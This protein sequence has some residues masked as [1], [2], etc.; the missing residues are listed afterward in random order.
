MK[1]I[2]KKITIFFALAIFLIGGFFP[3][4][5]AASA[6]GLNLGLAPI[7]ASGLATTDIR[8]IIANIIRVALGL[9]GIGAVGLIMYA[10][11][12]W[13]TAGGNEEQIATAKKIL[14]NATIGLIIILSAY[15]IVSF[16]ITQLQGATT[17]QDQKCQDQRANGGPTWGGD[18]PTQDCSQ[19]ADGC[20]PPGSL[21]VKNLPTQGKMC[22][23]N[24]RPMVGF[25]KSVDLS[26]LN[27]NLVVVLDTTT[28][29]GACAPENYFPGTWSN[30]NGDDNTVVFTPSSSCPAADGGKDCFAASTSYKIRFCNSAAILDLDHLHSLSCEFGRGCPDSNFITGDGVDRTP[31]S[32]I[33]IEDL[34]NNNV[35]AQDTRTTVNLSYVDDV[36]VQSILLKEGNN[37]IGS[38][39]F[40]GCNMSNTGQVV[41]DTSGYSTGTYHLKATG[42]DF[43]G[44]SNSSSIKDVQVVLPHCVDQTKNSDETGIDCGGGCPQCDG[45]SCTV[46]TDCQSGYCEVTN[47]RGICLEKMYIKSISPNP[48]AHGDFLSILGKYFGETAGH[49]YFKSSSSQDIEAPVANCGVGFDNWISNQIIVQVPDGAVSGTVRVVTAPVTGPDGVVRQWEDMTGVSGTQKIPDFILT[50][51]THPGICGILPQPATGQPGSDVS[52]VGKNF[53]ANKNTNDYFKFYETKLNVTN[54]ADTTVSGTVPLTLGNGDVG[55]SIEKNGIQ[56]NSVLFNIF[57][58]VLNGPVITSM[59]ATSGVFGDYLTIY[60]NNFGGIQNQVIFTKLDASGNQTINYLVGGTNFPSVCNNGV[61]W[62]DNQIVVKMPNFESGK[63]YSVQVVRSDPDSATSPFDDTKTVTDMPGNVVKPGICK[64]SPTSG[65]VPG[66]ITIFGENFEVGSNVYFSQTTSTKD[67]LN[68]YSSDT[69][70]SNNFIIATDGGETAAVSSTKS[71]VSGPVFVVKRGMRSNGLMFKVFDCRSTDNSN[72]CAGKC[73]VDGADA[74]SCI[75][76]GGLCSGDHKSSGYMWVFSANRLAEQP[77]VVERCGSETERAVSPEFPSPSPSTFWGG[78]SEQVCHTALPNVEFS[79]MMSSTLLNAT[80]VQVFSCGNGANFD[81]GNCNT[82]FPVTIDIQN[83]G[84]SRNYIQLIPQTA[85]PNRW[86]PNTWYQVRLI[87]GDSGIKTDDVRPQPLLASRPC[88]NGAA[89]YCFDFKTSNEDV[90][91]GD[92]KLRTVLVSPSSFWTSIIDAAIPVQVIGINSNPYDL[93]YQ[94]NGLSTQ[95]CTLMNV[96]DLNWEWNTDSTTLARTISSVH[97]ANNQSNVL[98][99]RNTVGVGIDGDA[100]KIEASVHPTQGVCAYDNSVSCSSNSDCTYYKFGY[101]PIFRKPGVCSAV[102]G[103]NNNVYLVGYTGGSTYGVPVLDCNNSSDCN[104]PGF[105]DFVKSKGSGWSPACNLSSIDIVPNNSTCD[106]SQLKTGT[107]S[108]KIDLSNPEVIDYAPNC[109]EAC[110]NA[111]VWARFNTSMSSHNVTN[112]SAAIKISKCNDENCLSLTLVTSTNVGFDPDNLTLNIFGKGQFDSLDVNSL[113]LVQL[114][115]TDTPGIDQGTQL[116][117][118]SSTYMVKPYNKTFSWRFR[119]KKTACAPTSVDVLPKVF[120]AARLDD[121]KVFQAD[122]FSAPDACSASGQKLNPW[123]QDWNWSTSDVGVAKIFTVNTIGHNPYCNGNCLKNGSTVPFTSVTSTIYP[124]C[125]NGI[126]E[127]GEDCDSPV[128]STASNGCQLNCL[129]YPKYK[130]AGSQPVTDSKDLN[131]SVC[132]NGLLGLDEDCDLGISPL[133]SSPTSSFLCSANCLHQGTRLSSAWCANSASTS[134]SGFSDSD[135]KKFCASSYSQCGDGVLSPDEDPGCDGPG[136]TTLPVDCNNR[137]LKISGQCTPGSVGCGDDGLWQGSSLM[138]TK[139]GQDY[140]SVCGDGNAATGEDPD[141][142]VLQPSMLFSHPFTDPWVLA[143][144]EGNGAVS[145]GVP[146]VQESDITAETNTSTHKVGGFGKYQVPCGFASDQQCEDF[147]PGSGVG[148]DSCCYARPNLIGVYPGTTSTAN[149]QE[150]VCINTY[151]EA[152]FD[153]KIDVDTLSGNLLLAR[154]TPDSCPVGST[155]VSTL[156]AVSN[157]K[158]LAWYEII[159]QKLVAFFENIFAD[160]ATASGYVWCAGL[161]VGT[162]KVFFN[163][164]GSSK[165]TLSLSKPLAESTV[166]TVILKNDIKNINGVSIAKLSGKNPSWMFKTGDHICTI[167]TVTINPDQAFFS[168]PSSSAEFKAFGQTK[169]FIAGQ[170]QKIQ[171]VA[172]YSWEYLW[173]PAVN[174]YVEIATSGIDT[175]TITSKNRNGELDVFASAN[176]TADLYEN[177]PQVGIVATGKSHVIVFLCEN[178]WPPK[179]IFPYEDKVGNNDGFDI[180]SSI[181]DGS[182]IQPSEVYKGGYFNFRTYYCADNGDTG[183]ADD[184]PYLRPV[185]QVSGDVLGSSNTT[186]VTSTLTTLL[187][188]TGSCANDSNRTC[189]SSPDCSYVTVNNGVNNFKAYPNK[190]GVCGIWSKALKYYIY[191]DTSGFAVDCDTNADCSPY[192]SNPVVETWDTAVNGATPGNYDAL[193]CIKFSDPDMPAAVTS[194]CTFTPDTYNTSVSS[195]IIPIASGALKRFLF[196]NGKNNDAVGIQVFD[197][198]NHLSVYAWL[199]DKKFDTSNFKDMSSPLDGYQAV[200]DGDNVY[201]DALN[202]VGKDTASTTGNLSSNIYLFSLSKNSQPETRK[203]FEEL[204]Q[205]MSFNANLTNFGYCGTAVDKPNSVSQTSCNSDFDCRIAGTCTTAKVSQSVCAG[206]SSKHCIDPA[207]DCNPVIDNAFCQAAV[208]HVCSNNYAQSCTVATQSTDCPD[209]GAQ[210]MDGLSIYASGTEYLFKPAGVALGSVE[211]SIPSG[212]CG[213]TPHSYPSKISLAVDELYI[214]TSSVVSGDTPIVINESNIVACVTTQDCLDARMQG[215][216]TYN[217]DFDNWIKQKALYD[218]ANNFNY[219]FDAKCFPTTGPNYVAHYA[220]GTVSPTCIAKDSTTNFA[221]SDNPLKSCT[222]SSQCQLKNDTCTTINVDVSTCSNNSAK[223]CASD[224]E[225]LSLGI[226]ADQTDKLKRDYQRIKDLSTINQSLINYFSNNNSTY[227]SLKE[228]SFLTGQSVSTWPS[229]TTLGNVLGPILPIDPINQL[230]VAGTCSVSTN[231]FCTTDSDCG[232]QSVSSSQK[233]VIHAA[234]TGWSTAD[235]RFSFACATDSLAYRYIVS[236]SSNSYVVKSRFEDVG[237][238][239]QNLHPDF[240]DYFIPSSDQSKFN[241]TSWLNPNPN[242]GICNQDQEISTLSQGKCG[243]GQ[244]NLNLGEQCDPPGIKKYHTDVCSNPGYTYMPVEVCG[245]SCQW[246]P[247]NPSTSSCKILSKCGNGIVEPGEKC[248]DGAKNGSYNH[249]DLGCQ[250]FASHCGDGLVSSTYEVCDIASANINNNNN[251]NAPY[252]YDINTFTGWCVGGVN[253]GSGCF[254]DLTCNLYQFYNPFNGVYGSTVVGSSNGHCVTLAQNKNRYSLDKQK[255]CNFDCQKTGPYCGDGVVQPEFGEQCDKALDYSCS[256]DG[257]SG[258][259]V[260]G[261]SCR[262]ENNSAVVAYDFNDV[263]LYNDLSNVAVS[264]LANVAS[265]S[266]IDDNRELYATCTG[267]CP[268]TTTDRFGSLSKALNFN[269]NQY[270]TVTSSAKFSNIFNL[271]EITISAWVKV[272]STT[273]DGWHAILSKQNSDSG[274]PAS[275]TTLDRNYNFY[276]YTQNGEVVNLYFSSLALEAKPILGDGWALPQT[277][278]SSIFA[279]DTWNFVAVTVDASRNGKF[280][281]YDASTQK[282]IQ[283]GS[284]F[285]NGNPMLNATGSYP[286]FIGR[287]DNFFQGSIDDVQLYNRA[288]SPGEINDLSQNTNN[289]CQLNNVVSVPYV[290]PTACGN[291][292]VEDGED[293]DLGDSTHAPYQNGNVCKPG[294]FTGCWYC[295]SECKKINISGTLL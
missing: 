174:P 227:P 218:Q 170:P 90:G 74:G 156:V 25:N 162:P 229:W 114:S 57:G 65:D 118:G 39:N 38:A 71:T 107:S 140:P 212:L 93:V 104:T 66:T 73:C 23:M 286:V 207:T 139:N 48:A 120:T 45:G 242:N 16:V 50:T 267:N 99:F 32:S 240:Y 228:G 186:T 133:V 35:I 9:L 41:W 215:D 95:Y 44:L 281:N 47:G 249:C 4:S 84:S 275:F 237:L 26:T 196:T 27:G 148:N 1:N 190:T 217:N 269:G 264:G 223:T 203:V 137:C 96:S 220:A 152:D 72:K 222:D 256:I 78:Q 86:A 62:N 213:I 56:S 177:P 290:A 236:T 117:S 116:W 42:W 145:T 271:N 88:N 87:G 92:C 146:P 210:Q 124:I 272:P 129:F 46:G 125:G 206:D 188:G 94:A 235:R 34:P 274:N 233:C 17:T 183:K 198:P 12:E 163:T 60:G 199:D 80:N 91:L 226:C 64:I 187:L 21:Y 85:L 36:G 24:V 263:F 244:V 11:Y 284:T 63:T 103:P 164:D 8:T 268:T 289:F 181:F 153:S 119:T 69:I 54:W 283:L 128:S 130:K 154:Y 238:D 247:A 59:S 254:N 246:Q 262:W 83:I 280:Y 248:D 266:L 205:N 126:V 253:D 18:C 142:E 112:N 255:S 147:N 172:G 101:A 189:A 144:G 209:V 278:T 58:S 185:V 115:T 224:S 184:L 285:T 250:S 49:V 33:T 175:A 258:N 19:S 193:G 22:I 123:Q 43:A 261:D 192:N 182:S 252:F 166:Y 79:A 265:S 110:T 10:G 260:C 106:F 169:D 13:M 2:F 214:N 179:G 171:P 5:N 225:C 160:K 195:Q 76:A 20:P 100:V 161:D 131:A 200:S 259:R 165:V 149:T 105:N 53:G 77:R 270:L 122:V 216:P 295:T 208:E 151:I 138:Y 168:S 241:L 3:F 219:N 141:C 108:L 191:A 292:V 98:A 113:Y 211:Q 136:I 194:S 204:I 159:W 231:I 40:Q 287:A 158:N 134:A 291:A 135:I 70:I 52:V 61:T 31:P 176:I 6:Q 234:D 28:D 15:S 37:P 109:L 294:L 277:N 29:K 221:C 51:T 150:N 202:F 243:D 111:T 257:Q 82:L 201:V 14:T 30:A 143:I 102:S 89:A 75:A 173:G 288:L 7:A 157:N 68:S 197:N 230:G 55:V 167:D 251:F 67:D 239:I 178:P 121:R 245:P 155:D 97:L 282:A 293:C 180:T 132:G 276:I 279:I 232:D 273:T 127:A 81:E